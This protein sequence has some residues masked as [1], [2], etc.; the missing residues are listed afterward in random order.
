MLEV[1]ITF[2]DNELLMLHMGEAEYNEFIS[3]LAWQQRIAVN[4]SPQ[5][6]GAFI[7]ATL[8]KAVR[9][10][11]NVEGDDYDCFETAETEGPASTD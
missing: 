7:D 3:A 6:Y 8:V 5:H 1:E 10:I 4:C 9:V 2:K 11:D